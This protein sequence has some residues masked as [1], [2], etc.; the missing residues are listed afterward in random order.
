MLTAEK[1]KDSDLV[2]KRDIEIVAQAMLQTRGDIAKA[3]RFDQVPFNA[4]TLRNF[5][6]SNPDV[7][8]RYQELLAEELE[9]KS[10]HIAERIL[11]MAELQEQA[12]GDFDNDIPPDPKMAIELSKEI[13]RLIAEAKDTHISNKSAIVITSKQDAKEILK[14]FLKGG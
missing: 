13:S 8:K 4:M 1:P 3:S 9:F 10:L 7:R 14:N 6:K 11:K 2:L 12:F 5:V